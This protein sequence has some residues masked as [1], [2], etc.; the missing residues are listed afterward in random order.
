MT[1]TQIA[2]LSLLAGGAIVSVPWFFAYRTMVSRLKIEVRQLEQDRQYHLEVL[3][4]LRADIGDDRWG[5]ACD[6]VRARWEAK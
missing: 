1:P 5:E 6:R 3:R 4:E 2:I